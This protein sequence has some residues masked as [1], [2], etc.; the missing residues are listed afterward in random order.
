MLCNLS[1]LLLF[2]RKVVRD[3][4][5]SWLIS[6]DSAHTLKNGLIGHVSWGFIQNGCSCKECYVLKK[7]KQKQ[8]HYSRWVYVI[9]TDFG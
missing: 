8:G 1:Q 7:V 2:E 9:R 3:V 4:F 5:N 6:C